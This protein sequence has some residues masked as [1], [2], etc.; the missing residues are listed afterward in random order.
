MKHTCIWTK[1]HVSRAGSLSQMIKTL[2]ERCGH[3]GQHVLPQKQQ[4]RTKGLTTH[5]F[6]EIGITNKSRDEM[7]KFYALYRLALR[8]HWFIY[9]FPEHN[10]QTTNK[11]DRDL[12]L[13]VP[14]HTSSNVFWLIIRSM[15]LAADSTFA[16]L[17]L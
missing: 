7:H 3:E 12:D 2:K 15:I 16:K 9:A 14:W 6:Y 5:A 8:C 13:F 4:S 11:N 10:K 17:S 1:Y